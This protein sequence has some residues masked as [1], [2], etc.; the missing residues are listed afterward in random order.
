M[1][2]EPN[3]DYSIITNCDTAQGDLWINGVLQYISQ[4]QMSNQSSTDD[5]SKINNIAVF[6]RTNNE[7][8]LGYSKIKQ[9]LPN[10]VRIRIQGASPCELWRERE[11]YDLVNTLLAH[12]DIQVEL[13]DVEKN[14]AKGIRHYLEDKM[15]QNSNWDKYYLDL[16][17]TLVLNYTES[18]RT[19]DSQ[20]T[21][22]EM[23]EYIKDIAGLDDGGQVYKIYDQYREKRILKEDPL[24]IILT[25]MHKVKGL[26][27]DAV[28]I[29]PSFAN[30]P[31]KPH[32]KYQEGEPLK[33]D[34]YADIEEER[35]LLFVAYTRAKKYLHVYKGEREVAIESANKIYSASEHN[36]NIITEKDPA[37][38]KYFLSYL[39]S[40]GLFGRNKYISEKVRKDD[41]V[42]VEKD[43]FDNFYIKHHG[44]YIGRL[45]QNSNIANMA[46]QQ[47]L[48]TLN[49]FYISDI[50]V[51]TYEETV[52]ADA[53]HGTNFAD[54]WCEDAKQKGFVYVVQIAGIGN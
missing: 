21:W 17:Y 6:F 49:G 19:D 26:E 2:H 11:I 25:T 7:V 24:T 36:T 38:E 15:S 52:K 22:A 12:P 42:F 3:C 47:R 10:N 32:N 5:F 31:L 18:I 27:F 13:R 46:R 9:L 50:C 14:T 45:S 34:D 29:T 54:S 41:Q 16:A 53:I 23:A 30:L 40:E 33:E 4:I 39:A 44:E 48:Q 51:W 20:H 43:R 1:E 35:R 28:F 8:Y 37:M